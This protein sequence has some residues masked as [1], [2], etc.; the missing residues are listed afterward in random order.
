VAFIAVTLAVTSP[1]FAM[2]PPPY[3]SQLAHDQRVTGLE[4]GVWISNLAGI[5]GFVFFVVDAKPDVIP[6]ALMA[7]LA[8]LGPFASF[9]GAGCM[10]RPDSQLS[11]DARVIP[12]FKTQ[13][14]ARTYRNG[15]ISGDA[16]VMGL[17][18]VASGV[19]LL[20][21]HKPAS[22]I[23]LGISTAFPLAYSLVN[24]RKFSPERDID[25][26][27]PSEASLPKA[28]LEIV[29]EIDRVAR[30]TAVGLGLRLR[31]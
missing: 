23:A 21:V 4:P 2:S 20:F 9:A 10:V 25:N 28:R 15:A 1:A 5:A 12:A 27:L 11:Q 24:I 19:M 31:F 6:A 17:N 29:P 30:E 14:E 8:S 3:C 13:E 26:S 7:N 18:F 16:L 22:R